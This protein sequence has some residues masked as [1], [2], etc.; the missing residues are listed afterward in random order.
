MDPSAKCSSASEVLNTHPA[1]SDAI[2]P[3][4]YIA[5]GEDSVTR[6]AG[7][8]AVNP[9]GRREP[10]VSQP[11]GIRHR[12]NAHPNQTRR[13]AFTIGELH[14]CR[15]P[16]LA[17]DALHERLR[18]QRDALVRMQVM[19]ERAKHRPEWYLVNVPFGEDHVDGE[20]QFPRGG[21]HLGS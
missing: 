16:A 7:H 21:R 6:R 18:M 15:I 5:R 19:H 20:A 13:H 4:G 14:T 17:D 1:P 2:D 3:A 8:V 9:V 12:A 10:A 11:T